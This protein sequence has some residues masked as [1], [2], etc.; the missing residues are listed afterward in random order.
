VDILDT[1]SPTFEDNGDTLL[2]KFTILLAAEFR[3][4]SPSV[5]SP[6]IKLPNLSNEIGE[7]LEIDLRSS[8]LLTIL[9][10]IF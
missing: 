6:D 7:L 8:V 1:I 10:L 4:D 9:L 5:E 3:T 2:L